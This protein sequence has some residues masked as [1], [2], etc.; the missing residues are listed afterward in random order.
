MI[1]HDDHNLSNEPAATARNI[2]LD[3]LSDGTLVICA[4]VDV[5]D[6]KMFKKYGGFSV[7]II[8]STITAHPYEPPHIKVIAN[9]RVID[10]DQLGQAVALSTDECRINASTLVQKG[11]EV[12]LVLLLTFSGAAVAHGFLNKAGADIYDSLKAW[13]KTIDLDIKEKHGKDLQCHMSFEI[14][15]S[16]EVIEVLVACNSDQ[17]ELLQKI[18]VDADE[19]LDMVKNVAVDKDVVKVVLRPSSDNTKIEIDHV[20]CNSE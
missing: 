20:V 18:G 17:I 7:S 1:L 6:D 3:N 2:R 19:I 10:E 14:I 12:P 9:P 5:Y 8:T 11:L 4:D 13:I 15:H 16:D